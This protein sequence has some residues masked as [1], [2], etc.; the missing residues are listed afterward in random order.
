[1]IGTVIGALVGV[2]SSIYGAIKS[3]QAAKRAENLLTTNSNNL[4]D[5]NRKWYDRKM[6]EDYTKR[7]DI[8][9]VLRKQKELLQE[10]YSRARATNA[11]AG[12]TDEALAMQQAAAN[13]TLGDTMADV[14]AQASSYKENAEEQ[15]RAQDAAIKQQSTQQQVGILQNQAQQIANAAGQVGKATAGLAGGL[16]QG[17]SGN[18]ADKEKKD[19]DN[20]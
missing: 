19:I 3:S 4:L 9:N 5:E 1:M 6:A 7:A 14:A 20:D 13:E 16:S 8:Q 11:V 12:G 2:G 17:I 18:V 15:Y 10:Q